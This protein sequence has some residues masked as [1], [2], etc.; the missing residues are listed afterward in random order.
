[1]Y[2]FLY[3]RAEHCAR[4]RNTISGMGTGGESARFGGRGCLV[5]EVVGWVGVFLVV[6]FLRKMIVLGRKGGGKIF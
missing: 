3:Q 2:S 1:M 6:K 5:G 4:G